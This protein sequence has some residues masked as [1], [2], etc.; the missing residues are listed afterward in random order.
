MTELPDWLTIFIGVFAANALTFVLYGWDKKQAQRH[1]WRV[2]ENSLLLLAL[3]G[4][5]PAAYYAASHFR[6][7]RQKQP[8]RAYM[9]LI[10]VLQ[11]SLLGVAAIAM[12]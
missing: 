4:G 8:F 11:V 12:I 10:V 6:H 9:A 2:P 3:L 5:T 1:G 7:K